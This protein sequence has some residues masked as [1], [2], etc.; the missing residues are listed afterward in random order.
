MDEHWAELRNERHRQSIPGTDVADKIIRYGNAVE[1]Q[2]SRAY[3][4]LERLQGRRQA[5]SVLPPVRP[6]LTQ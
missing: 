2:L 4:R 6:H 3:D 1:F 5:Q